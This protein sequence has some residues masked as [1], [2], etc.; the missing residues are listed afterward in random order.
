MTGA[1][2]ASPGGGRP[3]R[4][5][6]LIT[7][8]ELGGAQ[9][10]TID[11]VTRLDRR[12][13][14]PQLAA[15]PGGLL[16]D[17]A[18]TLTGAPY[19][20]IPHLVR[21]VR[22]RD[23][24]RAFAE[25]VA[26]FRRERPDIVHTNSSK[27]GV[28][29]RFAAAASGVPIVVH[30]VHGWG[31]HPWQSRREHALY[32]ALE[33]AAAR[34]T[35]QLVAV[36][37]AN[38]RAGARE[39]I[40]PFEAFAIIR[41]GVHTARF[42][43]ARRNGGLRAELGL[44]ETAP[45]AGMVGCLKPQKAPV[46]FVRAA[47]IAA[48]RIPD[49]HFVLVGDGVLRPEVERAAAEAELAGRFHLLG[50]RRDPEVVVGDLDLFVLSSLHE[51][52][53]MVV[54]EAMSAGVPVVATAVDGTPEAVADGVTG[55]LCPPRQPERL[56]AAIAELLAESGRRHRMAEA[57]AADAPRWDIAEMV[58]QQEELYLRLARQAG[59]PAPGRAAERIA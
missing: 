1:A 28:L 7:M 24:A 58:R 57:A 17:A 43:D 48:A 9:G 27:A 53:P 18:R 20:T 47:A 5:L 40:A 30:T 37:E 50:W 41:P 26:L 34:V 12:R 33:R 49:A 44:A 45:L 51:G 3:L 11:T 31:F 36:S 29:G 35:T 23:D 8:L 19:F 4:V 6:Q 46:D 52:L 32:V 15:G 16:D 21:E 39:E 59:L 25:M 10:L 54:P 22:P 38:A 56:G 2:P 55:L 13:F 42:R 14:A